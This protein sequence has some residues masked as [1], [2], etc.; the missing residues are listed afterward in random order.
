VEQFAA[1]TSKLAQDR[2]NKQMEA[3]EQEITELQSQARPLD[4][5]ATDHRE[6]LERREQ[7][8]RAA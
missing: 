7:A 6:A 4:E 2:A 1:L 8:V 3:L 5:V